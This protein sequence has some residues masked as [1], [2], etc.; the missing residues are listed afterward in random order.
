[1]FNISSFIIILCFF[2]IYFVFVFSFAILAFFIL[3]CYSDG[4]THTPN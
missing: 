2:F 3:F 1:M 4:C